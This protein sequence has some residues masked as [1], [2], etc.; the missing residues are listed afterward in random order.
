MVL[1][2]VSRCLAETKGDIRAILCDQIGMN[3]EL[4][5]N[6]I[7]TCIEKY[8]DKRHSKLV[9]NENAKKLLASVND[10]ISLKADPSESM[11]SVYLFEDLIS[12]RVIPCFSIGGLPTEYLLVDDGDYICIGTE[13][14]GEFR[15]RQY[16]HNAG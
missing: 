5:K 9:L 16:F 12:R 3:S 14:L 7:D 2:L 10:G 13:N 15:K 1:M 6:V 8:M 11:K 4:V